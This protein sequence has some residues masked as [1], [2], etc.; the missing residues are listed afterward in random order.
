[1]TSTSVAIGV[2]IA[3]LGA[4]AESFG[5]KG[6]GATSAEAAEHTADAII[7]Y[8]NAHG[9]FAGHKVVPDYFRVDVTNG[10]FET[11]AQ[12]ACAHWTEDH[13]VFAVAGWGYDR[14][15]LLGCLAARNT[16][17][18]KETGYLLYDNAFAAKYQGLFYQPDMLNGDRLGFNVDELASTGFLKPSNKIGMVRFD[19]PEHQR[20]AANVI[21][22]RLKAHNLVLADEVP[23]T[24]F[25]S[26]PDLGSVG[27]AMQ[28]AVLQ[29]RTKDI[30]RVIFLD[31][32]P[33]LSMFFMTQASS[34][35]YHPLYGLSTMSY[36]ANLAVNVPKDALHGSVGTGWNPGLDVTFNRDPEPH[37]NAKL[38]IDIVKG[39]GIT[40]A[41][42]DGFVGAMSACS[43]LFFL[44][45]A[46]AGQ[47][48]ISVS[49][50]RAGADAL[51]TRYVSALNHASRY[52]PGRYDGADSYRVFAFDDACTCFGY[53]SGPKPVS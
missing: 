28:N 51:G 29:F 36:P 1:V 16:P 38:C 47:K 22:P 35:G 42:R 11:Q 18:L 32:G 15:A 23:V 19:N 37:A 10:N 5:A 6:V 17:L 2:E 41:D 39:A 49:S 48:E 8:I 45:A 14:D 13:K 30:D 3:E 26:V 7:A 27:A 4:A 21:K 52:G 44:Q 34:Q 24:S 9:G 20:T 40:F 33:V 46:L 31:T 50:L 12:A 25:N 53:T 43:R